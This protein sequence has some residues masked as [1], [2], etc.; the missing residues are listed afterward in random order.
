MSK[1]CEFCGA[2]LKEGEVCSCLKAAAEN[3]AAQAVLPAEE[4]KQAYTQPP[5]YS[6]PVKEK[7]TQ[8]VKMTAAN[9]F[10]FIKAYIAAPDATTKAA[11]AQN[12]IGLAVCFSLIFGASVFI[13]IYTFFMRFAVIAKGLIKAIAD[14]LPMFSG[15][16][17][18]PNM[19][20]GVKIFVPFLPSLLYSLLFAA[21]IVLCTTLVMFF[22]AKLVGTSVSFKNAFIASGVS[23]IAPTIFLLLAFLCLFLSAGFTLFSLAIAVLSWCLAVYSAAKG[24]FAKECTGGFLIGMTATI[25]MAL[26]LTAYGGNKTFVA[27]AKNMEI[28][29]MPIS[30]IIDNFSDFIDD[31]PSSFN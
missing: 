24:L 15:S 14:K 23:F 8:A 19:L 26:M 9:I 22:S 18:D 27:V 13:F 6:A 31:F 25:F 17:L 20:R 21:V 28:N 5:V 3:T 16:E 7:K 30:S 1:F 12:D 4:E 2:P 10:P 11:V 29:E